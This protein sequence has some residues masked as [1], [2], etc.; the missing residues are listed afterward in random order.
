MT[1]IGE[2]A[3]KKC[4]SLTSITIGKGVTSIGNDA[5]AYCRSLTEINFNATEMADLSSDNHVFYKAGTNGNGITV[6]IGSNVTKIPSYLFHLY[7]WSASDTQEITSVVFEESSVCTS[8]GRGAFSGCTRLTGITIPNSVI[9]IGITAFGDCTSL[10]SVTLE[11]GIQLTNIGDCAFCDCTS[12]TSITIPNGVTNIGDYAFA[13]CTNLTSITIPNSVTSIGESAFYSY[14]NLTIYCEANSRP[15]GWYENWA[16]ENCQI[17]WGV[18]TLD[19]TVNVLNQNNEPISGAYIQLFQDDSCFF[20]PIITDESG[21]GS[22]KYLLSGE[23]LKAKVVSIN[24]ISNFYESNGFIYFDSNS[25]SVTIYIQKLTVSVVNEQEE[26]VVGATVQLY[27]GEQPF[28]DKL[29]TDDNGKACAYVALNGNT[30]SAKV[31]EVASNDE[32]ILSSQTVNLDN[33]TYD[34]KLVLKKS[35]NSFAC[36]GL[37]LTLSED[38]TYY[39]MDIVA[40]FTNRTVHAKN[41]GNYSFFICDSDYSGTLEEPD[42]P[43]NGN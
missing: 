21:T 17:V 30:L 39:T 38:S 3:F 35:N 14:T 36:N 42:I 9:S 43:L 37:E 8:I 10:T 34:C 31:T 32:Y 20:K 4:T 12:L 29:V 7:S 11:E 6:N 27:Q 19:I 15:T 40:I 23:Q 16:G 26:G 5:F 33:E 28:K 24:S 2:G 13:G 22:R 25:Y 1:S 41:Y 18:K